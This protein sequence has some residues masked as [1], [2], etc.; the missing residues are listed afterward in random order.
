MTTINNKSSKGHR[1]QLGALRLAC[2]FAGLLFTSG[3]LAGSVNAPFGPNPQGLEDTSLVN[4]PE[5]DGEA[6]ATPAELFTASVEGL[7]LAK[8]ASC[9]TGSGA[10]DFMS[11][12]VM[13]DQ[14]MAFAG[15]VV[16]GEPGQSSLLTKGAHAGPAWSPAET[17]TIS[18]WIRAEGAPA[19][20]AGPQVSAPTINARIWTTPVRVTGETTR[21]SLEQMG[22]TGGSVNVSATRTADALTLSTVAFAM[23]NVGGRFTGLVVTVTDAEGNTIGTIE[24]TADQTIV[25]QSQS[26]SFEGEYAVSLAGTAG[27]IFLSFGTADLIT[28]TF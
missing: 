3:C 1:N 21:L 18:N 15:L 17:S 6:G 25:R 19:P 9:H 14:V 12:D 10:V 22:V 13:R 20:G 8:C 4:L 11:A 24:L 23:A 2:G 16:P 27:D 26:L 28:L 5:V 7:L